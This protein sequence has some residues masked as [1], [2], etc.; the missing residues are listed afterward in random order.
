M[1]GG[2]GNQPPRNYHKTAHHSLK[3]ITSS[4]ITQSDFL[5]RDNPFFVPILSDDAVKITSEPHSFRT[6][7]TI[8]CKKKDDLIESTGVMP[9]KYPPNVKL[10]LFSQL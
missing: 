1:T 10:E 5:L 4:L 7:E 9:A 2:N 3:L 8:T 6:L